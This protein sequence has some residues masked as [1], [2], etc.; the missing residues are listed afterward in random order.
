MKERANETMDGWMDEIYSCAQ[1]MIL[2]NQ[3]IN[4]VSNPFPNHHRRRF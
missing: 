1:P 3:S 4:P 2:I